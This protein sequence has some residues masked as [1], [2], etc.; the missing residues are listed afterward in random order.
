MVLKKEQYEN[1]YISILIAIVFLFP[2]VSK[3]TIAKEND[4]R[5]NFLLIVADDLG[6]TELSSFGRDEPIGGEMGG[7]KW[8]RRGDDKAVMVPPP[9]G[10]EKWQLFNL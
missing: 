4:Q 9:Y 2:K 5:P 10:Q 7:G 1:K 3:R 8:L 6:W